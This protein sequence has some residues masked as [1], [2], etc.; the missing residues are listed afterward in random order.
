[1]ADKSGK[2]RIVLADPETLVRAGMRALAERHPDLEVVGQAA[3]G[4]ELLEE[5]ERLSPDVLVT[6]ASLPK[7]E[8]LEA[9]SRLLA[10]HPDLRIL[11]VSNVLD[12]ERVAALLNCGVMG[13]LPRNAT[14]EEFVRTIRQVGDGEFVLHAAVG[15]VVFGGT[16]PLSESQEGHN[17]LEKL[18]E[19][20]KEI[21]ELLKQGCSNKEIAQRLYLS[22]HTVEVHLRNIYSKLGVRSRLQAALR[23]PE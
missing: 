1:M 5:V 17:L 23:P 16:V 14:P 2:I 20:E 7:M 18:T 4:L 21:L 13:Y 15:R 10:R 9:V 11:V 8:A 12:R 6:E 3:D 22:V 19:R